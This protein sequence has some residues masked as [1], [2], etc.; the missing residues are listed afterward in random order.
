MR[1][2]AGRIQSADRAKPT[3]F[4][5]TV[6]RKAASSPDAADHRP[7]PPPAGGGRLCRRVPLPNDPSLA[8]L[9]KDAKRLRQAVAAGDAGARAQVREFHPRAERALGRFS[10]SDAQLVTARAYGFASWTRLKQHLA[11][12]EPLI[13]NAP[14]PDPAERVDAFVRLACMTYSDWHDRTPRRHAGCSLST[15]ASPARTSTPRRRQAMSAQCVR[16]ST[17]IPRS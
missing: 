12:V 7:S 11:E 15:P 3:R 8:H 16:S 9:R 1:G 17:V 5:R 10:L 2:R 13:W 6:V 14:P 4:V